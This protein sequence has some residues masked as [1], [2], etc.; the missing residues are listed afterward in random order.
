MD[1][2]IFM[3]VREQERRAE[4]GERRAAI[5]PARGRLLKMYMCA[6]ERELAVMQPS[7]THLAVYLS[8]RSL[9]FPIM[10]DL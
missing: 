8:G 2:G 9:S 4:R 6:G 3:A 10:V 1:A 5:L 7:S